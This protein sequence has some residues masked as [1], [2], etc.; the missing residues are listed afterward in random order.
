MTTVNTL[1]A[2]AAVALGVI[3][4]ITVNGLRNVRLRF[5]AVAMGALFLPIVFMAMTELLSHP[6]PIS[7]EVLNRGAS[8]AKVQASVVR[9]NEAIYLWLQVPGEDAPLSY[10]LPWTEAAALQL[11]KAKTQAEAQGTALMMKI[12]FKKKKSK[13]EAKFYPAAQSKSPVKAGQP[14]PEQPIIFN[15]GTASVGGPRGEN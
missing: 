1:F 12:P 13:E 11:H 6:K 7:L 14:D 2:I 5:I 8:E 3:L 4:W 10:M 15:G 9:E